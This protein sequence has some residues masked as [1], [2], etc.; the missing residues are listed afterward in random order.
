[1]HCIRK[2]TE[3]LFWVGA[4]DRRLALFENVYP[5]PHGV[6]YNAYVLLDEKTVLLD[7]A[8]AAVSRAFLE[9]VAAALN[10]RPLDY[11][12][13]NHME[14]DHCAG[15]GDIVL[16]YPGVKIVC[17]ATSA[18]MIRQFFNFDLDTRAVLV[19]EGDTLCIGRH[20]LTF[21]MAPMVHWPEAMVTYDTTDKVLFSA[22]AFGTF[23][24]INGHLFADE[25]DIEG[26]IGEFRRYY[27]NIVGKY[28]PQVQALLK[29]AA[30]LEISMLCPLHGFVWR[31]NLGYILDKYQKWSTYTPEEQGVLI[32]FGSVYGDTEAAAD[33]LAHMLSQRGV[34]NIAMYDVSSTHPSVIVSEAFRLSHWVLAAPTYNGGIFTPMEFALTELKL[35]NLQNRTA[36]LLENGS[37]A[38][39]SGKL[40]SAMLDGMKNI[41][42]L[43]PVF[44]IKSS[45]KDAQLE[46]LA[47]LADAIAASVNG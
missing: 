15:I 41:T 20:T 43:E 29:K 1:M 2:I 26:Q 31:K 10:G 24:A 30:G 4:S 39:M 40:M 11:L 28:G 23:G 17:N 37:W 44:S 25:V 33:A 3:D 46:N 36:A 27:T 13:V 35:H 6:S 47:A 18:A 42:R 19:K 14:P 22:D 7:T 21:V 9:N 45:V 5:I 12:V 32:A 8:D 34:E 38:P 16:R